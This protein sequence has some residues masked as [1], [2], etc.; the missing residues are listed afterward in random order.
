VKA[1]AA[2]ATEAAIEEMKS[3]TDE[4]M[5]I[6][7]AA[8]VIALGNVSSRILGLVRETVISHLFGA[9]GM[10]SAFRVASLVPIR[11][12]ELLV[13][14]MISAA[15]VP[16]FSDYT[17][18]E[19]RRELWRLVS[20]LF[21]VL[22]IALSAIVIALE[23]AAPLVAWLLGGGFDAPLLAQTTA[24]LRLMMPVVVFLGLAGATTGFLYANKRFTYPA[25]GASVFNAGIIIG[26][27]LLVGRMGIASLSLG[28]LLGSA[29]Q[30][31]IQIPGL[32]DLQFSFSWGLFHPGLRRMAGLY[33]PVALGLAISEIGIAIDRNMAS[34]T[35]E[36][37]IAWM[38]N[39]T[40]LVQFP[41]G[42]VAVAVST[43]VLPS[44][45]QFASHDDITRFRYT[46]G[47]GL[48]I[49]LLLIVP[50]TVGLLVLAT[51]II[52][53]VF[54]HG[55]FQPYDTARTAQALRVY[56]IGL[57]FAAID[58]LLIFAFYARKDTRTPVLV[59][60]LGVF[61]YIGVALTL[62]APLGMMGLVL[63]NSVQLSS[64]A[65]VML[66]LTHRH[67]DGLSGQRLAQTALRVLVAS[68]LTGIVVYLTSRLV[69]IVAAASLWGELLVV[70]GAGGLGLI[71][72]AFLAWLLRLEEIGRMREL[73]LSRLKIGS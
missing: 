50:A 53:L 39:A 57:P 45:S 59:G 70:G 37:S 2:D 58:Q 4:E 67:F 55:A 3:T 51:P 54:E 9:T 21:T 22:T 36:Q 15:L 68:G 8:T 42:L 66:L 18:P 14:G 17:A 31:A 72:Y 16:V 29:L 12:N 26:A 73:A 44:L 49:V 1:A 64:H 48:R 47:V 61:V 46:L 43:A 34:R 32:R 7:Q 5:G 52:A 19:Q 25:F 69:G 24:L 60:V 20:A 56:L 11:I 33:L 41:L 13:G 62:I 30:L 23:V 35:G 27:C 38:H 40:T 6:A 28:V 65:L 63:A 10:V 71:S